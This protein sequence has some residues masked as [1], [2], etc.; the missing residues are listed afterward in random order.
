MQCLAAHIGLADFANIAASTQGEGMTKQKYTVNL[1]Q[2][3]VE[4]VGRSLGV[5]VRSVDLVCAAVCAKE[6][7]EKPHS[8]AHKQILIQGYMLRNA[9]AV[10]VAKGEI[11]ANKTRAK[12]Q[13]AAERLSKPYKR[14]NPIGNPHPDYK[15]DDAFYS[16][17]VWREL[18]Y[19]ALKTQ[20]AAC[21]CCGSTP[22]DGAVLH[23]DHV[24]PIYKRPDL[25]LQLSNLQ[26]LCADCNVGKGAWDNTDWR[27][28]FKSI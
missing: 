10:G 17:S 16:S 21:Q 1:R 18:R 5:Q 3:D 20:G 4:A 11:R 15:R 8:R 26:I 14:I 19:M 24:E 9:A 28:H 13:R 6:G 7:I 12:K 23:V 22:R 2:R 25:K 27:E